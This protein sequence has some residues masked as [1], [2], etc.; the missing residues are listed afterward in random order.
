MC[1]RNYKRLLYYLFCVVISSY[2]FETDIW[3][4]YEN[5]LFQFLFELSEIFGAD[6]IIQIQTNNALILR[7]DLTIC[8][9]NYVLNWRACW[10]YWLIIAFDLSLGYLLCFLSS[11]YIL[12]IRL[13]Q[14]CLSFVLLEIVRFHILHL[15]LIHTFSACFLCSSLDFVLWYLLLTKLFVVNTWGIF[16][17][18]RFW[19]KWPTE[20]LAQTRCD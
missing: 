6:L 3:L 5:A 10:C 8:R 12:I 7:I 1:L 16:R 19:T 9:L 13:S 4:L 14:L 18:F 17:I 2:I 20:V 11:C 15:V